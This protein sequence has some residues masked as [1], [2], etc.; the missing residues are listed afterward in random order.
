[1]FRSP[2]L[3]KQVWQKCQSGGDQ[4]DVRDVDVNVFL[5]FF[6]GTWGFLLCLLFSLFVF[7]FDLSTFVQPGFYVLSLIAKKALNPTLNSYF[8]IAILKIIILMIRTW[9]GIST[10]KKIIC[11]SSFYFIYFIIYLFW[12]MSSKLPCARKQICVLILSICFINN[13]NV[14][15]ALLSTVNKV[16]SFLFFL[17]QNCSL[18]PCDLNSINCTALH[19]FFLQRL[20]ILPRNIRHRERAKG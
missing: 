16:Y 11:K 18:A 14:W 17:P 2:Y 10:K 4:S 3:T 7:K 20:K 8:T 13:V 19:F 5:F 1:M 15:N 9:F 12:K 6:C